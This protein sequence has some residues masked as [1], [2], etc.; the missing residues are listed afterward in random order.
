MVELTEKASQRVISILEESAR[1]RTRYDRSN[2]KRFARL[3]R[4]PKAIA[5]TIALTDEVMRI[6]DKR[7]AARTF[8]SIARSAPSSLG[9]LDFLGLKL[10]WLSSL[11]LPKFT[12]RLV[13]W[14]VRRVSRGVILGA[15]AQVLAR[16]LASR[17]KQS[18]N[19]NI[20]VLG[21]A[22]LGDE[23]AQQ[24][25]NS[26]AEVLRREEITYVSVKV[27]SIISQIITIDHKGTIDRV[28]ERLRGLYRIALER[29]SFINLD[30]E[31]FRDLAITVDVFKKIL[32]EPEFEKLSAGIVLQA[33]LP[34][35]HHYLDDL[36]QWS[37][38]RFKRTGANIK[39]R[40]V[41][42]ANL[43]MEKA[44]AE[45][46]GWT[47]AP[48]G[49]KEEVDASYLRL[50]DTSLNPDF[51]DAVR[52]GIASHNLFHISWAIELA[53][54]RGV[55]DQI[56]IEMLEGMANGDALA[57][58]HQV[59][60]VLLYTPVTR[61]EDFPSAVAYLVRR[62]DENTSLENYLRASF[63]MRP[64]S[65]E[66]TDQRERFRKAVKDRWSID[67]SSR[68]HGRTLSSASDK[69]SQQEFENQPDGDFTNSKLA[70]AIAS[71]LKGV[72]KIGDLQIPV[73]IDGV[74]KRGS[75][76][77]S[78]IDPNNEGEVWYRYWVADKTLI[79]N[80][81]HVARRALA[82]WDRRDDRGAIL[83][84]A[85][86]IMEK[87]R[88][89]TIAVMSRDTGK[90]A[91]EG[92][93]EVS[94]AIDFA[95]YYAM[96]ASKLAPGSK[97]VG[98]VLVVP[99]WNFPYA[100]PM[101]GVCAALATGNT[102]IIKPAPEAVAVAWNIVNHL[103]QAGVP[104]DVL[105]FVPT[106]DD[107]VGQYLVTHHGIDSVILTGSFDTARLFHSWK[108]EIS[109]MAETS[110]KNAIL[111]TSSADIDAAV[112]DL[113]TSAFGHAG[114][115]C[116]A[117]SLAI[118]EAS[119]YENPLFFKQLKDAV[120]TLSVGAA[121]NFGTTVGPVIRP[122]GGSLLR[123][124]TTLDDGESWLVQPEQID[125]EGFIWRPGVKLG[126]QPGSW[127][128][129]N[130]WFG[131]VLGIMKA[132]DFETALEWQN[133]VPF[134]LTAG[135]H[136]LNQEECEMWIEKIEAGN[137]YVNRQITGAVV[138]RQPFGGWKR[139]SVGATSKA[140]G[141]HYVEQLRNWDL[142]VDANTTKRGAEIWFE[143]VGKKAIDPSGLHVERNLRRYR[144]FNGP[145][146]VRCDNSTSDQERSFLS[147]L[148][149]ER[150]IEIILSEHESI[151]EFISLIDLHK[152]AKVRW[153]S[154]EEPPTLELLDRG[155]PLD[156][157]PIAQQ[158]GVEYPRWLLEQSVSVTNHRY[159][160]IGVGPQPNVPGLGK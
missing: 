153:L 82:G 6:S 146:V 61:R 90:T 159:G 40:I 84:K 129:L 71:S 95:R 94:E 86:E 78:G 15:E 89:Q 33:Y 157:R 110:G 28:V 107:E 12:M 99:P 3:L 122:A 131:P 20:N 142:I 69:K 72:A 9:L 80:A 36:I 91:A 59:G 19:A 77:E 79:N 134:G 139:S 109:L 151:S 58:A 147:W 106:C 130:E 92:D 62:L 54:S 113:V 148:S 39:I 93:P 46:H 138:N 85:C 127:S 119:I 65:K 17:N 4:D 87:A 35:S 1:F 74:E 14:R 136:S 22:V 117:A 98:V 124:L 75:F 125:N 5:S 105:Q 143:R 140:G 29:N 13:E 121:P 149:K 154:S 145:V 60:S 51:K 64:M 42:G 96:T 128:H 2:R 104:K 88:A 27:S 49:S 55:A 115:K 150:G 32:D 83:L 70:N 67:I 50:I 48:F 114:Q 118:V 41:K 26:V 123:A 38:Q 137:L 144:K 63:S 44:E 8:Q 76:T 100:I 68:R 108:P 18:V 156:G 120:R 7:R 37:Q 10:A 81:I 16:H 57:I 112:K 132:P 126:V 133:A 66:F 97:P 43:A 56:D 158:G 31:E 45:L 73:V 101:G 34:E 141:P 24:R 11:I 155:I 23:E 135:I 30:M 152:A 47:P 102:V 103:W 52:I 25:W 160:N 53:E 116:S 21:E 111:I